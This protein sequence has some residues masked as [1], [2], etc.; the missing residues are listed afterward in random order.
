MRVPTQASVCLN[1]GA[2]ATWARQS[3]LSARTMLT[4]TKIIFLKIINHEDFPNTLRLL[5]ASWCAGK[6]SPRALKPYWA[7]ERLRKLVHDGGPRT[8]RRVEMWAGNGPRGPGQVDRGIFQS[9]LIYLQIQA[10]HNWCYLYD[11]HCYKIV[12]LFLV[13][14]KVDMYRDGYL[15]NS[16]M[17]WCISIHFL[18]QINKQVAKFQIIQRTSRNLNIMNCVHK[19]LRIWGFWLSFAVLCTAQ[20]NK[21]QSPKSS[22]FSNNRFNFNWLRCLLKVKIETMGELKLFDSWCQVTVSLK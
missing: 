14:K 2:M 7:T 3:S 9:R 6:F 5:S 22:L 19:N 8:V 10:C 13:Q 18:S 11:R 21:H 20:L 16:N 1:L 17:L 4:L 15:A 12:I